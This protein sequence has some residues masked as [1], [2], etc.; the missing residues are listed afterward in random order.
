MNE[1]TIRM[2]E[3]LILPPGS[4]F[5]LIGLGYLLSFRWKT[6]GKVLISLAILSLYLLCT[7]FV[8]MKLI[9]GLETYPSLQE[10]RLLD[11]KAQ[12]IVLLMGASVYA[13][14]Y[15]KDT[16]SNLTL[17][18]TRYAAFLYKKTKLPILIA[19]GDG[20]SRLAQ[21]VLEHNFKTPTNW[22]D[23]K[24][25]NTYQNAIY[26]QKILMKY[27]I[28]RVYLVTSAWHMP[29][30]MWA[31]K[32]MGF[33]PIA[34]PTDY[35]LASESGRAISPWLPSAQ[36]LH[37]SNFALHEYVGSQWYRWYY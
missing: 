8:S 29:R 30:A 36:S 1:V 25:Q 34:A 16:V 17:A 4:N 26:S 6:V 12:A 14:E 35:Q 20:Q 31:F 18:R 24:S 33:D 37:L 27:G 13:P 28:S 2:L 5:L 23:T 3:R 21:Q 32:R 9:S 15:K 10:A 19:G 22:L 11:N 7:P